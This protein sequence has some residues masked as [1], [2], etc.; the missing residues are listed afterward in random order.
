MKDLIEQLFLNAFDNAALYMRHDAAVSTLPSSRMAFSTDS[1][2]VHPLFF[3]GGDIGSLAVTG[4]VNDLAMAGAQPLQMSCGF[5]LEEGLEMDTLCRIV[6][7]MRRT[8]NSL[9]V[10]ITTGDT[11]VVDQGKGDGVY[12][13]TTGVGVVPDDRH[14]SPQRVV[15]GDAV[16][17]S[18]DIGR[19]G[20]AV[21]AAR[22]G[23]GFNTSIVSDCEPLTHA[24]EA[25]FRGGIAI[26]CL[27]DLT[28]G[29]LGG[30]LIEIA[31]T[32]KVD[33]ETEESAIPVHD[34]V[35]GACEILGLDPLYVACEGRFAVILPEEDANN[36]LVILRSRGG[37]T[38]P[39]IIGHVSAADSADAGMV[40]TRTTIG[41]QRILNLP[42]GEQL[43][44][45]C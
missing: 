3:P 22:E 21:M 12:I 19:H 45:I 32:A 13:N 5:I 35:T 8:A 44:R 31:E 27:R 16:L 33:I 38:A 1:Y 24:V 7:S 11:K 43:P 37:E 20:L 10:Q 14:V 9:G 30:A 29:G 40:T 18:G 4:T 41:A 17:V 2:V 26:H 25:L 34:E 42:S 36:A 23:L 39:A 6:E 28:R 15:P